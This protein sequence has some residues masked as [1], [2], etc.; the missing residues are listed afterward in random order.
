VPAAPDPK[1]H[2]ARTLAR[3]AI[4][5][6]EPLAWFEE[7]YSGAAAEWAIPWADLEPNPHLMSW[8]KQNEVAG[9]GK[10]ALKVGCGRGDDAEA[11]AE[12]GFD[13]LAF[14]IS[15]TAID[16]CRR[17]FPASAVDYAV[18]DVLRPPGEWAGAFD[19]V[20]ESYTLQVL[21]P[22]LRDEAAAGIAATVAPG[23]TLLAIARGRDEDGPKGEM[24][25]P[26]SPDELK[27]YFSGRLERRTFDDYMDDEDPPVRRLRTALVRRDARVELM[28]QTFER[29][30]A[31]EREVDPE[32]ADP[33]IAIRS[34]MTSAEYHGYDGVRTWMAE[35]DEQFENWRVSTDRYRYTTDGRL[36]GLETVHV[37]GRA[38]GV[39]FDQPMAWLLAFRGERLIELRTIPDHAEGLAAARLS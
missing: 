29:W 5:R 17:R 23:G 4:E 13:V 1:R 20:L 15:P 37:R 27:G 19:L 33:G 30:N 28:R 8:L 9:L 2:V 35:I 26:L 6:G 39:E 18:A 10:R 3:D 38:S 31:G 34:A 24:P 16:W 32:I 7:L 25:W 12:L 21:P 36:L 22:G 14:D 11:L